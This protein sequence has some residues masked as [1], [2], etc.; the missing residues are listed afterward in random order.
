MMNIPHNMG[1]FHGKNMK[2]ILDLKAFLMKRIANANA[3][4]KSTS[5][6]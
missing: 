2:K 6:S 5:F 1:P 3:N 4:A